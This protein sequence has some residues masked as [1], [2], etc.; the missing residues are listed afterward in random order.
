MDRKEVIIANDFISDRSADEVR[1]EI[2][3]ITSIQKLVD[4]YVLVHN[5]LWFIEDNL[6]DFEHGTKEY[7]EIYSEVKAWMNLMENLN[8]KVMR[9]A[10]E[11][12]ILLKRQPDSGT[13][14]Q[15]E[16]FMKKYGYQDGAG[17]WIKV[18]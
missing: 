13:A 11:E 8:H 1:R 2:E 3:N 6:Y 5:K 9:V 7:N 14:K 4:V 10:S 15:L 17:W 16:M 18:K 12:G